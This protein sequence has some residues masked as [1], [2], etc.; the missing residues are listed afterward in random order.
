MI[1]YLVVSFS[2][3]GASPSAVVT[4]LQNVGF[5]PTKGNYDFIYEWDRNAH[6]ED[7]IWLADKVHQT[8]KG[9]QVQFRIETQ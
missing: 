4:R 2:S 5:K 7:V 3:E 9:M 6:V 1:S 8:L